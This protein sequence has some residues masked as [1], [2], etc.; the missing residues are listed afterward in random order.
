MLEEGEKRM[1]RLIGYARVSTSD[2]DIRLQLDALRGVGCRDA[3]IF[4]DTASGAL[5]ARPG[6]EAC[7]QV[8]T[9]GDTLV[10]WRLDR[11]GRSMAHLVTLIEGLLQRQ[12]GFRSLGDGAIDTTTASGELVFNIFSAL[13]QFERRLIQERTRAGLVAARARGKIGGRRPIR[14]ENPRVQMAYALYA[15]Q[16]LT[17]AE[18]CQALR[19]SPATFYRYVALGKRTSEGT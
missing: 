1:G 13:A 9:P 15:A 16:S 7:L 19:I 2:Q 3:D 12:V 14:P 8:L 11:L 4:L 10:V 5:P 17:A 18:I 6:L